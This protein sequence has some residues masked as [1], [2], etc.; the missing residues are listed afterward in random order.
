MSMICVATSYKRSFHSLTLTAYRTTSQYIKY[1]SKIVVAVTYLY[2]YETRKKKTIRLIF[3]HLYKINNTKKYT[4]TF[5]NTQTYR[6]IKPNLVNFFL[7]CRGFV[8]DV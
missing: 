3:I 8:Y 6:G 2:T 1:L 7:S 5:T 4:K